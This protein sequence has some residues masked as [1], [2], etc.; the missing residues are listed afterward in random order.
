M[1]Q[2]KVKV[3][4]LAHSGDPAPSRPSFK[5]SDNNYSVAEIPTIRIGSEL[6]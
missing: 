5:S 4:T 6:V 2:S 3:E 1:G